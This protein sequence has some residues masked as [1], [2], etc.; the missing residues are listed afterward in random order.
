M[1]TDHHLKGIKFI[2][3]LSTDEI[4]QCKH[5][6]TPVGGD[7]F[8]DGVN[9]YIKCHGYKLLHMGSETVRDFEDNLCNTTIA[10][11]GLGRVFDANAYKIGD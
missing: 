7:N 4:K 3:R 10:L 1:T 11:V 2:V 6:A 8:E 9:H 5:C